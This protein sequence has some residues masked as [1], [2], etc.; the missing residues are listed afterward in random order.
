MSPGREQREPKSFGEVMAV[1][2]IVDAYFAFEA[3]RGAQDDSAEVDQRKARN[4][5]ARARLLI[6]SLVESGRMDLVQEARDSLS[7][8]WRRIITDERWAEFCKA[9][10]AP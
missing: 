8:T 4:M 7:L 6:Q 9:K 10:P 1:K 5:L 3:L 2:A